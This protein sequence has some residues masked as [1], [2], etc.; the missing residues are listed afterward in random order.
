MKSSFSLKNNKKI[1]SL[2]ANRAL[3]IKKV[4]KKKKKFNKSV[5]YNI[6][7]LKKDIMREI[8]GIHNEKEEIS[9][10]SNANLNI[11]KILNTC[12]NDDFLNDSSFINNND[13]PKEKSLESITKWKS[14]MCGFRGSP[15][16]SYK[17]RNSQRNNNNNNNNIFIFN[18][19]ISEFSSE[20]RF[21]EKINESIKSPPTKSIFSHK[22]I[23][24]KDIFFEDKTKKKKQFKH[25][26]EPVNFYKLDNV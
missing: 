5:I 12:A 22:R 16:H 6:S 14:R 4:L 3:K 1:K 24:K 20:S 15:V 26:I 9:L 10:L 13:D 17:L 11:I 2:D 19:N 8:I 18:S 25:S 21:S 7:S 23:N